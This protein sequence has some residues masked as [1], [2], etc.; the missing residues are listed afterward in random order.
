MQHFVVANEAMSVS[1][2]RLNSGGL[3]TTAARTAEAAGFWLWLWLWEGVGSS[4]SRRFPESGAGALPDDVARGASS[5]TAID[6]PFCDCVE[7]T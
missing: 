3:L 1:M 6:V 5:S 2:N 7:D 4:K